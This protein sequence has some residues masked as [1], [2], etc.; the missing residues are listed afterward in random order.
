MMMRYL[1]TAA[2]AVIGGISLPEDNQPI[3]LSCSKTC[4]FVLTHDPDSLLANVERGAALGQVILKKLFGN[5]VTA[6]FLIAFE[7]EIEEVKAERKKKT[8]TQTVLVAEAH[9]E[10]N[11]KMDRST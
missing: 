7:A 2:W 4:R 5:H 3:E 9:G 10:T 11:V 8:G 6:E 1:Y